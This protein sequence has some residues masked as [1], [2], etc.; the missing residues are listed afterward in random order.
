M[1]MVDLIAAK[2]DGAEHTPDRV[3]VDYPGDACAM[4]YP[5]T[6]WRPG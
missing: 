1:R 3:G 2:R 4:R 5:I 6:N